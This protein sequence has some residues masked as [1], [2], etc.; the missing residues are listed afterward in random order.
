[1]LP[2]LSP[3]GREGPAVSTRVMRPPSRK[4]NLTQRAQP[5]AE[6]VELPP[7]LLAAIRTV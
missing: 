1:V 4:T 2:P 5:G 3:A 7:P 6:G